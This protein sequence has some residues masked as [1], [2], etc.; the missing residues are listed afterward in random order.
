[1]AD[2]KL[3][4]QTDV[5]DVSC[6][7]DGFLSV[8]TQLGSWTSFELRSP[9][10][11]LQLTP[12]PDQLH[13]GNLSFTTSHSS[14]EVSI[15]ALTSSHVLLAGLSGPSSNRE[16][17]LLLWDL[18]YS[19]L[20]ASRM[21][22]IP[23][24]LTDKKLSLNLVDAM[25]SSNL[26]LLLTPSASISAQERRKSSGGTS[27]TSAVL[28]VPVVVPPR[29]SIANAMGRAAAG[30]P[31]LAKDE[32]SEGVTVN[33]EPTYDSVRKKVVSDLRTAMEQNRPQSANDT[34]FA[35]EKREPVEKKNRNTSVDGGKEDSESEP[36]IVYGYAFVKDVLNAVLRPT[37]PQSMP[38]SSQVVRHLLE[39]K[40]VSTNMLET[41]LLSVL[42]LR[43]DWDSI[44]LAFST[45]SDL[46]E[47]EIVD[48]LRYVVARHRRTYKPPASSEHDSD[49]EVDA[50]QLDPVAPITPLQ[51][52]IPSLQDYMAL[53]LR[54]KL[55]EAPFRFALKRYMKDVDDVVCLLDVLDSWIGLWTSK[56]LQL[57]PS[58][59]LL[60]KNEF[61]IVT[62]KGRDKENT[63]GDTGVPAL[64]EVL[65]FV[66]TLLDI[67]FIN[68]I[69]NPAS[70]RVLRRIQSRIEP[71]IAS[72]D[73]TE[74]LRGPLHVFAA[75]HSKAIKDAKEASE[76][77]HAPKGDWRQ[78][79][80]LAQ[81]QAGMGIGLYQLEELI[82]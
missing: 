22:P 1:M 76:G 34:F 23:T 35:W 59:K 37:Q 58:K 3:S 69:Q 43:N 55:S 24:N 5:S 74:R 21:I 44:K 60:E 61:G 10:N 57:M 80:K 82:L 13:L 28:V 52:D 56:E 6:C 73:E 47:L 77:K 75:T 33:G 11:T 16:I 4:D 18:Q 54:Y 9:D 41:G 51:D 40:L 62:V 42:R 26:L 25:S 72:I 63:K 30:A 2:L 29:S 78:K 15:I 50:M 68:L 79:R 31:W 7:Q 14:E 36:R 38:Y 20:L 46:Q 53:C 48:T 81:D 67:S 71:E 32:G 17:A 66:Q 49:V 70:H 64:S 27:A 45:V 65:F 19:V 39:K 8:L 12:L